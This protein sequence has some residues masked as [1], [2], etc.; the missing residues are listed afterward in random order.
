[1]EEQKRVAGIIGNLFN[2]HDKLNRIKQCI[3]KV[4]NTI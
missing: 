3:L 1:M 4:K 2:I